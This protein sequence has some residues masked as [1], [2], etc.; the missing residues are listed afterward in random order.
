MS[1]IS[2]GFAVTR[3]V[4]LILST[5]RRSEAEKHKTRHEGRGRCPDKAGNIMKLATALLHGSI[6]SEN[7]P[8]SD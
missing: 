7:T 6:L 8:A 2:S 1:E 5:A 4:A 3:C